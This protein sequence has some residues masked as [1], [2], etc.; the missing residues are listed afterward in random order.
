[1]L[2]FLPKKLSSQEEKR[3][4]QERIRQKT[5][6]LQELI[7]Q[8]SQCSNEHPLCLTQLDFPLVKLMKMKQQVE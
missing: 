2:K 7:L 5:A 4:R 6:Q 8:V 1:M 3:E